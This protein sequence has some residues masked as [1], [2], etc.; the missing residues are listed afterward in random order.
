[1]GREEGGGFRMG[2]I[3]MPVEDSFRYLAK[4][5]QYY[6]KFKNKRKKKKKKKEVRSGEEEHEVAGS[7]SLTNAIQFHQIFGGYKVC[8]LIHS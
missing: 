3:C 1:M 5:I 6:V 2:N 7:K 8:Y 4:P